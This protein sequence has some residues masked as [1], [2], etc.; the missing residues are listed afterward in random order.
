[1]VQDSLWKADSHSACQQPAFFIEPDG[2]L[3]CSQKPATGPYP[4]QPN[5]VCPIDPYFSKIHINVM[6]PPTS[7]SCQ[8][9][10][11]F[12]PLKSR[13]QINSHFTWRRFSDGNVTKVTWTGQRPRNVLTP[14]K[15]RHHFRIRYWRNYTCQ[16]NNS[17]NS[18]TALRWCHL[19]N[20]TLSNYEI[21]LGR[22]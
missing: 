19:N 22:T 11:T 3:S 9:S 5:S 14:Y 18:I 20:T 8:W 4:S 16:V 21:T 10:L 7:R 15:S 13:V 17:Q 6:L 1:M 12:G 2:S